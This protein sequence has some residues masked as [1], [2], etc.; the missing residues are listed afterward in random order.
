M[1]V[2][3]V[4]H[5]LSEF[6]ASGIHQDKLTNLSA[7]GKKQ[8]ESLA[9]RFSR[10]PIDIIV[11]SPYQRTKQTAEII[12]KVLKKPIKFER[13]IEEMRRPSE[14]QGKKRDSEKSRRI[15]K[16]I[17]ENYH[18]GD[19][20]YSDEETFNDLKSRAEKAIEYLEKIEKENILVVTHFNII[21]M[22]ISVMMH[23]KRL[24]PLDF[25]DLKYF[26]V[27][28]PTGISLCQYQKGKGW[29]LLNWNDIAH[30]G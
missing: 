2:Y 21:A 19:W 10:I 15:R 4:R 30:L 16:L 14:I 29:N 8:A 1:K 17:D 11:A 5:A 9:K 18:Q 6:D 13:L 12:G 22:M 23:G 24:R 28:D 26:F 3:F 20:H 7:E 25:L 27:M